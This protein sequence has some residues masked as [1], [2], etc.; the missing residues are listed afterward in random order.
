MDVALLMLE[1][2]KNVLCEVPMGINEKQVRKLI[3]LA[4]EKNVFLAEGILL[5]HFP[6]YRYVQEQIQNGALGE[7]KSV[8]VEFG[9]KLTDMERLM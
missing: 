2:G 9:L 8:D 4:K 1:H 5:R 6:A 3:E 7:I